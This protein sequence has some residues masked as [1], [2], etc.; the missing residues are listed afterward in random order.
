MTSKPVEI[1]PRDDFQAG[2]SWQIHHREILNQE[3]ASALAFAERWALIAAIPD[4]EDSAGRQKLRLPTPEELAA[5][6]CEIVAALRAE[7]EKREWIIPLP[8]QAD[9]AEAVE[10]LRADRK[11]NR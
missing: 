3:A 4:G 2:P 8:S 1:T 11:A 9:A 6:S 10:K 7:F 5:R